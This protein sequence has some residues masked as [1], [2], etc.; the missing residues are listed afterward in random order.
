MYNVRSN[1][2]L[3]YSF[4]KLPHVEVVQD[5]EMILLL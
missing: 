3:A 5:L 1:D 2:W 4:L